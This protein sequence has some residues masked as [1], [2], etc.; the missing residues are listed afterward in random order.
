VAH[1]FNDS[2]VHWYRNVFSHVLSTKVREIAGDIG[3]DGVPVAW[4]W[5]TVEPKRRIPRAIGSAR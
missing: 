1:F 4:T 2:I 5:L 3:D